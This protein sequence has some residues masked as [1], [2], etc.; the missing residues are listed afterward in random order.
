MPASNAT[1]RF[2]DRL[3][4]YIRY[5]PGYP[6]EV[7]D[8][9]KAESGLKP[10]HVIA[11]IASGTGIWIKRLARIRNPLRCPPF[12]CSVVRRRRMKST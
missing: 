5:H 8:T 7:I 2:S 9:L 11:D 12:S 4:N 3:E 10:E 6:S 1:S